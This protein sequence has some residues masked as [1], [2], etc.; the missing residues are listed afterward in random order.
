MSVL[1][2]V[3]SIAWPFVALC[4]LGLIGFA[5]RNLSQDTVRTAFLTRDLNLKVPGGL[6][7]GWSVSPEALQAAT[8]TDESLARAQ[9]GQS[10]VSSSEVRRVAVEQI[11]AGALRA[12]WGWGRGALG[13]AASPPDVRMDWAGDEPTVTVDFSFPESYNGEDSQVAASRTALARALAGKEISITA[14]PPS[15]NG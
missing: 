6:E 10:L 14:T 7:V 3:S 13:A 5:I 9:S 2:F 12:G 15:S 4:A 8:A 1:Q 11:V